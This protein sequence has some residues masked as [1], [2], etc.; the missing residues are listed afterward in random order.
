MNGGR[1]AACTAVRNLRDLHPECP[2]LH[3][4]YL[5][6]QQARRRES[7]VPPSLPE[8]LELVRDATCRI[9]MSPSQLL[10]LIV[11]S[12]DRYAEELH[13]TTASV[14]NLCNQLP[15]N[16]WSPKD[17]N[18]LSDNIKRHLE[19]DL[20]DRSVVVNREVEIRRRTGEDG[21]SGQETDIC[22]NAVWRTGGS[23]T[24][25][26]LTVI[27]EVKGCWHR[28]VR[29]AMKAQLVDRYLHE[30]QCQHGLYL[31]GWFL[32]SQ[33]DD[34][35]YRKADTPWTALAEARDELQSQALTL[36]GTADVRA[37]LLDCTLR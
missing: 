11:E 21:A 28:E 4:V 14:A 13:G 32:C 2:W 3:N 18:H 1:S 22:L 35:D 12:L 16:K 26:V 24:A 17:E 34:T 27:I 15:G 7:W 19:V 5:E 20:R 37:Y 6:A 25:D 23:D 8:F 33:W 29:T 10:D 36:R 30:N 31:V 9:I